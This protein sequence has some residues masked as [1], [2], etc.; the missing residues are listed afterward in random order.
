MNGHWAIP[1]IASILLVGI[2]AQSIPDV[3]ALQK[4]TGKRQT[5]TAH[6]ASE[7]VCGLSLCGDEEMSM[8]QIILM[9][10]IGLE[11]SIHVMEGHEGDEHFE[12]KFGHEGEQHSEDEFGFGGILGTQEIA[13]STLNVGGV[14]NAGMD[15]GP[16]A[17]GTYLTEI[18]SDMVCGDTLCDQPMSMEEKIQMYLKSRGLD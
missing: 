1:I 10:L 16:K 3:D 5:M 14:K 17:M 2:V 12:E 11:K 15:I 6:A 8:M 4:A 13:K 18:S 7:Q 9:Y